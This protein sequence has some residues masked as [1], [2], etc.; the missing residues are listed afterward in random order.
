[1][2]K[3]CALAPAIGILGGQEFFKKFSLEAGAGIIEPREPAVGN[4][5]LELTRRCRLQ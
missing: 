4:Q 5:L 2:L 3:E 1:M